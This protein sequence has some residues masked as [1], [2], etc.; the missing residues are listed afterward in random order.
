MSKVKLIL[1]GDELAVGTQGS[2]V[3]APYGTKYNNAIRLTEDDVVGKDFTKFNDHLRR[4]YGS[5]GFGWTYEETHEGRIYYFDKFV[6]LVPVEEVKPGTTNVE[7]AALV[8]KDPYSEVIDINYLYKGERFRAERTEG[9]K[10]EVVYGTA[11][12]DGNAVSPGYGWL[13]LEE[14]GHYRSSEL[15]K[16]AYEGTKTYIN[17]HFDHR[18]PGSYDK[19][20]PA[21]RGVEYVPCGEF[22]PNEGLTLAHGWT[23]WGLPEVNERKRQLS[24]KVAKARK[25]AEATADVADAQAKLEIANQALAKLQSS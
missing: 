18:P 21:S 24:I 23:V 9:N 16:C 19:H 8:G 14:Q 3:Q 10:K 15:K 20:V 12:M 1:G 11:D 4:H 17:V 13:A 6:Y 22:W 25:L 5:V 2:G 7:V